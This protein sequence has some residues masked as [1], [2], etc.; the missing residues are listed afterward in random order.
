MNWQSVKKQLIKFL[1]EELFKTG[2]KKATV[3]LSGGLDSAVVAILCKE[4]FGKD[5]NCVLLPSLYSSKSSVEDAKTL[6]DKFNISYEIF[7]ISPLIN[8]YLP[9]MKQDKLRIGNFCARARMSVL[10]DI[11]A[12]DSSL[13]IGTS[14]RSELLL[15]YGTIF[16]DMACALDPLAQIYK[17]DLFDFAK[18]LEVPEAIVNKKPSADLWENQSDEEDLGFSYKVLDEVM[19]L[20][21]DEKK[22]KTTLLKLGY[23]SEVINIVEARIRANAFK[24]ELPKIAKIDWR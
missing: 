19:K 18:F 20:L 9:N 8:A 6:C 14:N 5:L 15:G 17:T 23:D 7:D 3:G 22:S 4:A 12:R 24:T 10:Y 16:G 21:V 13:V 2:L 11:S 1:K